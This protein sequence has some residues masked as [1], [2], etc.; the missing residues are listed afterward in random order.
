MDSPIEC[1]GKLMIIRNCY[2]E[3]RN[4]LINVENSLYHFNEIFQEKLKKYPPLKD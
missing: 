3:T 1:Y 4:S 2:P